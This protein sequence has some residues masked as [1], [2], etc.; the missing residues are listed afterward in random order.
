MHQIIPVPFTKKEKQYGKCLGKN[1]SYARG[2]Y[3]NF[4]LSQY[5]NISFSSLL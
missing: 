2:E 5:K 4:H 1:K 3:E